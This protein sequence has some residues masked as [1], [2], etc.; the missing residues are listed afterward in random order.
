M[1]LE[2][3]IQEN[4]SA[5]RDLIATIKTGVPT[6]A[7]EAPSVVTEAKPAAKKGKAD[8]KPDVAQ[9]S[10]PTPIVSDN[11][12]SFSTESNAAQEKKADNSEQAQGVDQGNDQQGAGAQT[13]AE[14]TTSGTAQSAP[15][16]DAPA[17]TFVDTRTAMMKLDK[18][19]GRQVAMDVL[20]RFGVTKLTDVKP[21]SFAAL[22][23]LVD[24][25]MAGGE[26]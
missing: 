6:T 3:A 26:V 16:G 17:P 14:P 22:I 9:S 20:S 11:S 19:K 10:E 8:P 12:A 7:A 5:L 18:A 4:T 15:T 1:S 13:G 21:E 2:A 23:A 25:V 24:E